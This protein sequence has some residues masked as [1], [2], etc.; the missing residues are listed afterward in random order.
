MLAHSVRPAELPQKD[1][2][3]VKNLV[4]NAAKRTQTSQSDETDYEFLRNSPP[5]A[6]NDE[7]EVMADFQPCNEIKN[8][9]L[10]A[11][12]EEAYLELLGKKYE[13]YRFKEEE[14]TQSDAGSLLPRD[15]NMPL[16]TR[17][18]AR[19]ELDFRRIG[20]EDEFSENSHYS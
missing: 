20:T 15:T 8:A 16:K 17:R 10:T 18:E 11:M 2:L 6:I 5:I 3:I 1:L 19:L 9:S 13:C 12:D 14:S 4:L 7:I